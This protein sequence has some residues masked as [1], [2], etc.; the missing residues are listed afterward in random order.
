MKAAFNEK[1][2][3]KYILVYRSKLNSHKSFKHK[4]IFFR[5]LYSFFIKILVIVCSIFVKKRKIALENLDY[6][7]LFNHDINQQR[8]QTL[9]KALE[10][11]GYKIKKINYNRPFG[12]KDLKKAIIYSETFSSTSLI[13]YL[14]KLRIDFLAKK[15]NPK[16]I[17]TFIFH[18]E[19]PTLLRNFFKDSKVVFIPHGVTPFVNSHSN[20]D[21]DYSIIFGESSVRNIASK[22]VRFGSTKVIKIGS[23][24]KSNFQSLNSNK[25]KK[26]ILYFSTW[27][28]HVIKEYSDNF[29]IFLDWAKTQNTYDIYIKLHPSEDP[30][31]VKARFDKM[32]NIKILSKDIS[33]SDALKPV[34]LVIGTRTNA[35][36]EA[37]VMNIPTLVVN[38]SKYDLYSENVFCNDKYLY[39]EK[40]FP[41]R[42][43]N[44]DQIN[45]TIKEIF[46]NYEFYLQKCKEFANFH[47]E[48]LED[49][50]NYYIDVLEKIHQRNE[51]FE[52]QYFE[53]ILQYPT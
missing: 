30:K 40:F 13:I 32:T 20:F 16:V 17:C 5:E 51:S 45:T 8:S 29:E 2:L 7:I 10:E 14:N 27:G 53:E 12:F 44:A 11:K 9:W 1:K 6:L 3:V 39:L 15:Y 22:K 36:I 34:S 31:Y 41:K 21:F 26:A 23:P 50:N 4:V 24:F 47:L 46:E 52:Y 37:A 18:S 19:V 43:Q 42:S 33:F 25:N 49:S 38:N 48:H 35:S 28:N